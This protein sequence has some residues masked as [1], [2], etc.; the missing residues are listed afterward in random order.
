METGWKVGDWVE[1]ESDYSSKKCSAGGIGC[2]T[3]VMDVG[4]DTSS[5]DEDSYKTFVD[6]HYLL[7]NTKETKLALIA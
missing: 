1:V 6:V 7:T 5:T 2:V 3:T 4:S